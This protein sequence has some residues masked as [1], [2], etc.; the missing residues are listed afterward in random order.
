M[1]YCA[2]P[3]TCNGRCA[4]LC[5]DLSLTRLNCVVQ[6]SE[7]RA[8]W[9]MTWHKARSI[10][11]GLTPQLLVASG[12]EKPEPRKAAP[13]GPSPGAPPNSPSPAAPQA[14]SGSPHATPMQ[15]PPV[16]IA[17]EDQSPPQAAAGVASVTGTNISEESPDQRVYHTQPPLGANQEGASGSGTAQPGT[18]FPADATSGY[19][20]TDRQPEA[21]AA[22]PA[23]QP[24]AAS[25]Q[26]PESRELSATGA[27]HSENP[28]QPIGQSS[29][30]ASPTPTPPQLGRLSPPVRLNDQSTMSSEPS[31]HK[32]SALEERYATGVPVTADEAFNRAL[33][34][35][36]HR[37]SSWGSNASA[38]S[39]NAPSAAAPG[40]VSDSVSTSR[41][42]ATIHSG[43]PSTDDDGPLFA[44]LGK[45]VAEEEAESAAQGRGADQEQPAAGQS[46]RH[47]RDLELSQ[48]CTLCQSIRKCRKGAGS[49]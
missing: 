18:S 43:I 46:G 32:L 48:V 23:E 39:L 13:T 34:Q 38:S 47:D 20:H 15:H 9:D 6:D 35:Q 24:V 12:L 44:E 14:A 41:L 2:P 5:V 25:A 17:E 8:L 11:S 10:S 49:I 22:A 31:S 42:L 40:G 28:G 36:H 30:Y 33:Q 4:A 3:R 26:L 19:T 16:S 29:S 1:M 45:L 7:G 21:T 37:G 27:S